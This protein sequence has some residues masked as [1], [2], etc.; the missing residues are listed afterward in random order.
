MIHMNMSLVLPCW[1]SCTI[2]GIAVKILVC[3]RSWSLL[4]LLPRTPISIVPRLT[5][6]VAWSHNTRILCIAVPLQ[7]RWCKVRRLKISM[8]DLTSWS[9]KSLHCNLHPLLL[10]RTGNKS[11]RR[12]TIMELH[13]FSCGSSALH[14][15]LVLHNS[16]SIF[17]D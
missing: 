6:T 1:S 2:V 5:T 4:F 7:W 9:L 12:K 17:K 8:L 10:I 14:L 15:P 3:I 13:V 16:S 11:L